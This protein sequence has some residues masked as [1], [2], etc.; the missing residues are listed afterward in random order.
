MS[1]RIKP[2]DPIDPVELVEMAGASHVKATQSRNDRDFHK[3]DLK[4]LKAG[5]TLEKG[6][7]AAEL[8]EDNPGETPHVRLYFA[9]GIGR[10][11]RR[12]I[13]NAICKI[14][15]IKNWTR[16]DTPQPGDTAEVTQ[17]QLHSLPVHTFIQD[18]R[19]A[20]EKVVKPKR[21]VAVK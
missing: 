19:P 6:V 2:P 8:H 3:D 16:V 20:F 1:R 5:K 10:A 21:K 9:V 17:D 18:Q 7:T 15:G 13:M 12:V 14:C 11:A 4:I